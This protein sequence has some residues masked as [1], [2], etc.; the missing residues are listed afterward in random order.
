MS[1][2]LSD[3]ERYMRIALEE[4]RYAGEANE[5]PIGAVIVCNGRILS[6][7]HN[8]TEQLTDPTAHAEIL[9]ITAATEALGA[10]YLKGC[11]LYVTV[12]PCTMCAGALGWSQIDRVVIGAPDDKRGF[13]RIA[14]SALHPKT[15]ITQGILADE[16]RTMMQSFFAKKR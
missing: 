12:E 5:V 14:P 10:K 13:L 7:A 15:L 6:R 4:A 11:T 1:L 3:D 9:A 16:S 2:T 8:Q